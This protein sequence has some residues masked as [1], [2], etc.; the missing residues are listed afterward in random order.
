MASVE[1]QPNLKQLKFFATIDRW[2]RSVD[3]RFQVHF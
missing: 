3:V 1:R 2:T